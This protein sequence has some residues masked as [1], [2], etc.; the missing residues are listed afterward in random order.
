[1]HAHSDA[2][3]RVQGR[4]MR[5]GAATRARG[6]PTM[7]SPLSPPRHTGIASPPTVEVLV[8]ESAQAALRSRGSTRCRLRCSR[9][10]I[11]DRHHRTYAVRARGGEDSG[12]SLPQSGRKAGRPWGQTRAGAAQ[13]AAAIHRRDRLGGLIH[14]YAAAAWRTDFRCDAQAPAVPT[15]EP[16]APQVRVP[17]MPRGAGFSR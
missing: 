2:R 7:G 12:N 16:W 17:T 5:R 8:L 15:G 4:A 13:P 10:R 6:R 1:M 14:E 11:R 3:V 9:A